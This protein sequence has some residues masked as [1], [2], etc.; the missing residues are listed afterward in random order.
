M[1]LPRLTVDRS[2]GS[3]AACASSSWREAPLG[4]PSKRRLWA[5]STSSASRRRQLST[6][7]RRASTVRACLDTSKAIPSSPRPVTSLQHLA[8]ATMSSCHLRIVLP[9]HLCIIRHDQNATLL[10]SHHYRGKLR[11]P[12]CPRD[13]WASRPPL[14]S[15]QALASSTPPPTSCPQTRELCNG[16]LPRLDVDVFLLQVSPHASH[17]TWKLAQLLA[18]P[19]ATL[20]RPGSLSWSPTAKKLPFSRARIGA[21]LRRRFWLCAVRGTRL[22]PGLEGP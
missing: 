10:L 22:R 7:W 11:R 16:F 2:A 17:A 18:K 13:T 20:S 3:F 4:T 9:S 8:D 15:R 19:S 12:P 5:S 14:P 6:R 21:M 1:L